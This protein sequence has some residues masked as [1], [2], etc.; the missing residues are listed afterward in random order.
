LIFNHAN[1]AFESSK[2]KNWPRI[3]THWVS[4]SLRIV[5]TMRC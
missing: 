4:R 3:L 2:R 5:I 1:H